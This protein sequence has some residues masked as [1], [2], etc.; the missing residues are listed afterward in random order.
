MQYKLVNPS[1]KGNMKVDF[2]CSSE[3]K[4]AELAWN[5]LSQYLTG[6]IPKFHFTIQKGGTRE[7][8]H[9]VAEEK[10]DKQKKKTDYV[11]RAYDVNLSDDEINSFLDSMNKFNKSNRDQHGGKDDKKNDKK[12]NKKDSSTSSSD[13]DTYNNKY[14]N[15][16]L[17]YYGN[18]IVY[19]W[20]NPY[21][22][23]VE[24]IYVPTFS[25]PIVPYVEIELSQ[26][27]SAFF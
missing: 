27:S 16:K 7:L 20:Y 15:N 10:I 26:L 18:P 24:S 2:S 1:I 12:N 25:V 17:Y 6:N 11:A 5:E 9:Y 3:D 22:Y 8:F 14:N 21:L 13:D 23:R 4:A 19:Y